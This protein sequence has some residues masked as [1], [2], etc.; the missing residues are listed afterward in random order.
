MTLADTTTH[1]IWCWGDNNRGQ[2]GVEPVGSLVTTPTHRPGVSADLL[3]VGAEFTCSGNTVDLHCWGDNSAGQIGMTTTTSHTANPTIFSNPDAGARGMIAGASFACVFDTG[4]HCWGD[5]SLG[6]Y[7]RVAGSNWDPTPIDMPPGT[8][9]SAVALDGAICL[10]QDS[11]AYCRGDNAA[12]KLFPGDGRPAIVGSFTQ[13]MLP[14]SVSLIG[15]GGNHVCAVLNDERVHCWGDNGFL[16]L[17]HG[18]AGPAVNV[19]IAEVTP[20]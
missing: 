6:Q 9:S 19:G 17:G 15:G 2:S 14:S 4:L 3:A 5:D 18:S 11:D 7:G 12:Q 8:L 10:W 1:Q 16:Q 13:K 20:P